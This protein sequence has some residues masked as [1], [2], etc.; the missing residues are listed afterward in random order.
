MP[1]ISAER[2]PQREEFRSRQGLPPSAALGT[3]AAGAHHTTRRRCQGTT[4]EQEVRGTAD[5]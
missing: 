3:R 1:P 4:G 5:R 2:S